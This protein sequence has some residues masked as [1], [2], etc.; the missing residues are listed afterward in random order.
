MPTDQDPEAGKMS[1]DEVIVAVGPDA[2]MALLTV[3]A[4][5]RQREADK[6]LP[7]AELR[8]RNLTREQAQRIADRLCCYVS[9]GSEHIEP[10]I[11]A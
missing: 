1:I 5:Y 4:I 11:N 7:K 9:W 3:Q 2:V 8:V 6:D 10:A